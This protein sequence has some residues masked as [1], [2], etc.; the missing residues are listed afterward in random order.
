MKKLLVVLVVLAA[1][2]TG[3]FAQDIFASYNKPGNINVYVSG[4]YAWY[5]EVSAAAEVMI[6]E[7]ALGPAS[8]DW[9]LMARGGLE[10]GAGWVDF[11]VGALASMH[12]GL[13]VMPIEFYIA[14][15]ACYNNWTTFPVAFA[16]YNGVTY[17]FSKSLGVVVEGGYIGWYFWGV[18]LEFKL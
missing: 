4:G 9:G 16:S 1:V 14:L 15:G 8:V 5:F 11:G 7:F 17:W 18:G 2:G 12:L 3:A 6:G 13:A 10:I